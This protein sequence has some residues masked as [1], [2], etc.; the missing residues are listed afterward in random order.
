MIDVN[1]MIL[2]GR[3]GADP[4]RR[5]TKQGTPVTNF[6]VATSRRVTKEGAAEGDENAFTEETQWHRIVAWG[7]QADSCAQYLKKGN[8]VYIE[9]SFRTR[10]YQGK[11]GLERMSWEVHV[12]NVVFL[13]RG[14]ALGREE[15][16]GREEQTE[17]AS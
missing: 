13:P 17:A 1:K 16:V 3:L 8:P 4:I 7:K 15:Q 6:P 5:L 14:S 2:I 12:E 9:G 10:P 11:D